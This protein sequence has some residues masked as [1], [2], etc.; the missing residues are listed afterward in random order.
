MDSGID[1]HALLP[2]YV[3]GGLPDIVGYILSAIAGIA[4]QMIVF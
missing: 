4:I 2:D 3:F 1:Y